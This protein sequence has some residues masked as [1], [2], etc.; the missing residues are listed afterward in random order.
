MTFTGEPLKLP[1]G[2]FGLGHGG[3]AHAPDEYWLVESTNPKVMG[4]DGAAASFVE[5]FAA[6]AAS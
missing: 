1:A 5:F 2:Q 3:G 6:C 4:M